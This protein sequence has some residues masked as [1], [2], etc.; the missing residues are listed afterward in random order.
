MSIV[1]ELYTVW[2]CCFTNRTGAMITTAIGIVLSGVI[3]IFSIVGLIAGSISNDD[4]VNSKYESWEVRGALIGAL[5]F[6]LINIVIYVLLFYGIRNNIHTLMVPWLIM[7]SSYI[8]LALPI[9]IF[10]TIGSFNMELSHIT[11]ANESSRS[12]L[13]AEKRHINF[14]PVLAWIVTA[15]IEF[16]IWIVV[17]SVYHDIRDKNLGYLAYKVKFPRHGTHIPMNY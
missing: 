12:I 8:I 1:S 3:F 7:F 9:S 11:L 17:F 4:G 5:S 13:A 6:S 10:S 15:P 16:Y 14:Y 2:C